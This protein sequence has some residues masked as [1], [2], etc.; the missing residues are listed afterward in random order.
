MRRYPLPASGMRTKKDVPPEVPVREVSVNPMG[1]ITVN[2]QGQTGERPSPE[3]E[4]HII[5]IQS[6]R[7][8]GA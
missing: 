3:T 6:S 2:Q 4:A 1:G 8:S 7:I 5:S